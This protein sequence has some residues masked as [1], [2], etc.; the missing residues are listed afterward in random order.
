MVVCGSNVGYVTSTK[1]DICQQIAATAQKVNGRAISANLETLKDVQAEKGKE[2]VE[3]DC[4][5][6]TIVEAAIE[7][8][9]KVLV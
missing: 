7:Y 9:G 8:V 5:Q 4:V 3:V 6:R 1:F 2:M